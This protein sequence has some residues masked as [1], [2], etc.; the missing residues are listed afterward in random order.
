MGIHILGGSEVK[1]VN[2]CLWAVTPYRSDICMSV[3]VAEHGFFPSARRRHLVTLR[4]ENDRL[5]ELA[6]LL[7]CCHVVVMRVN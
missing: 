4:G 3:G 6:I 2:Q 5:L 7:D 1:K